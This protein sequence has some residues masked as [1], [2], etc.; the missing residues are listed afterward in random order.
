MSA[1]WLVLAMFCSTSHAQPVPAPLKIVRDIQ[2][3]RGT[4]PAFRL[5]ELITR[6]QYELTR[7]LGTG[8]LALAI[9]GL[10]EAASIARS[11]ATTSGQRLDFNRDGR[12]DFVITHLGEPSALLINR[13]AATHRWCTDFM[14]CILC[15]R[16][17]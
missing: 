5:P 17:P 12:I 13:T 2:E 10:I 1:P 7:E 16:H 15:T 9:L 11:V 14:L 6:P 3:I 4:L 8:A